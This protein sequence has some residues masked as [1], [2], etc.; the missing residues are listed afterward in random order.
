MPGFFFFSWPDSLFASLLFVKAAE[1]RRHRE[2]S[3]AGGRSHAISPSRGPET[4][5]LIDCSKTPSNPLPFIKALLSEK[6]K[7]KKKGKNPATE[8]VPVF[9][10]PCEVHY[11]NSLI[12]VHNYRRGMDCC[13]APLHEM[14]S[15]FFFLLAQWHT[16]IGC[17]HTSEKLIRGFY[18]CGAWEVS[19]PF[20]ESANGRRGV[21]IKV[22]VGEQN[23]SCLCRITQLYISLWSAL[24]GHRFSWDCCSEVWNLIP[25]GGMLQFSGPAL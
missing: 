24:S 5:R 13:V 20:A 4:G 15:P 22:D 25:F 19:E 6:G 16:H 14:L 17:N 11:L 8:L 9:F 10:F 18:Q 23:S 21:G 7:E 3:S 1:P 12:K 2:D